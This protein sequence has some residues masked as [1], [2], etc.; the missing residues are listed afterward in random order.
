[1]KIIASVPTIPS[2]LSSSS[3]PPS[4]AVHMKR[5]PSAEIA[6]AIVAAIEACTGARCEVTTGKPDPAMLQA[7]LAGLDVAPGDCVMVGDRL[8]TDIRMAQDGGLVAALVLTGETRAEDLQHLPPSAA[9]E[10]VLDRIDRLLPPAVWTELGWTDE[11]G[12]R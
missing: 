6:P 5:F 7:A 10:L 2:G 12:P 11:P 3:P 9:P 4:I 8:S 1:M